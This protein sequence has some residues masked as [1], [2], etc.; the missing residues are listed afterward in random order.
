MSKSRIVNNYG[1]TTK[2]TIML[3]PC[4]AEAVVED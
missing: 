1:V 3:L 2:I 4:I